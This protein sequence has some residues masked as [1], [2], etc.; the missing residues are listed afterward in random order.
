ML[1]IDD[2]ITAF[3]LRL[4]VADEAGVLSKIAEVLRRLFEVDLPQR[5]AF[6]LDDATMQRVH[7]ESDQGFGF[8]SGRSTHADR[9]RTIRQTW[10]RHALLV[11]PHTADALKVALDLRRDGETMLVLETALPAKF[12]ETIR[13][14]WGVIPTGRPATM[15]SR[16]CP[17]AS[18]SCRRRPTR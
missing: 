18:A 13:E 15:A 4:V 7:A 6:T 12:G 5:G 3:Y 17:S 1:P 10:E 9:L 16:R 14:A 2:V 8:T 11:D